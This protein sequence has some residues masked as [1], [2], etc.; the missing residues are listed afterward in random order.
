MH[1]NT[2]RAEHQDLCH[3]MW[4]RIRLFR[5]ML[6]WVRSLSGL[7]RSFLSG[8]S[9]FCPDPVL[10]I[11]IW[12]FLSGSGPFCPDPTLSVRIWSSLAGSGPFCPDPVLSVRIQSFLTGFH[13]TAKSKEYGGR[14]EGRLGTGSDLQPQQPVGWK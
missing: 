12:L 10:S 2:Q 13:A 4:F 11:L 14:L 7:I 3:F 5:L 1:R 9:S 8:S 6:V